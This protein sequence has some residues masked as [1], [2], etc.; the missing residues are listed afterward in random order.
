VGQFD[1]AKGVGYFDNIPVVIV[2]LQTSV[3]KQFLMI[4]GYMFLALFVSDRLSIHMRK[5]F[6]VISEKEMFF[7]QYFLES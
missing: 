3:V 6:E 1:S 4:T 7:P 2:I 5:S